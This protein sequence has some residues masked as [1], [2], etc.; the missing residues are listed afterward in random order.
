MFA[1]AGDGLLVAGVGMPHHSGGR[2]VPEHPLDAAIGFFG[3]VAD[4][5]EPGVLRVPHP[6]AA[7]VMNGNP[8]CPARGVQQGV[9]ERPVRDRVGAVAHRLGFA[10]RAR[11]RS[12]VEVIAA[13][14]HGGFQFSRA[15][16][17]VEREAE[18]VALPQPHP[19]DARRQSLK[20]DVLPS[21]IQPVVEMRIVGDEFLDPGVGAVDVFGISRERCPAKRSDPPAE[22]GPDIGG[23]EPGKVECAFHAA[24]E[25]LLADVVAV[26][27]GGHPGIVK[28]QHRADMDGDGA[29]RGGRDGVGFARPAGMPLRDAPPRRQIAVG[30]IVRRSLVG[31]GVGANPAGE[32]FGKDLRGVSEETHGA[33][34]AGP[35]RFLDQ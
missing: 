11:D 12:T 27:E 17:L 6:D 29:D 26:V 13:D 33:R 20:L 9:Q 23:H 28:A 14:D 30:R 10:V 19:A 7:A 35:D 31:Q 21:R 2:V 15:D 32:E 24:T 8:R 22:E 5:D 1:G 3:A 34:G 18:P 4:D 16:H 25:R